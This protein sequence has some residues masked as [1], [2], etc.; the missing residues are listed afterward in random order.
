MLN[1]N[2]MGVLKACADNALDAAG[3]DF[4]FTDEVPSYVPELSR[5]QV[6]GY[7]SDLSKKGLIMIDHEKIDGKMVHQIT[8]DKEA[9]DILLEAN[10]ANKEYVEQFDCWYYVVIR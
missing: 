10:M 4:G 1:N 2:E 5:N 7:L 9:L 3:G 8:L 6:K